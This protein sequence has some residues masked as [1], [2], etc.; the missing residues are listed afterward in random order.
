MSDTTQ[1]RQTDYTN[2]AQ[3]RLLRL[4]DL[5]AG[6]EV[7]GLAPSAI[8]KALGVG[9]SVITRDLDNLKRA[10]WAERMPTDRW[11]LAPHVV[12]LSVRFATGLAESERALKDIAQRFGRA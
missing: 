2:E 4:I 12:Q 11:R 3:Q 10:G 9:P 1:P 7:Q 6:H 8:A 5:L